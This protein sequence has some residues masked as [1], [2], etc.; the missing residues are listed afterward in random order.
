M[1]SIVVVR[2]LLIALT[3]SVACVTNVMAELPSE[4]G[5]YPQWRGPNRDGISSDKGLLKQWPSGGPKVEEVNGGAP[6][7]PTR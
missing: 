6:S 2:Q 5:D 3:L 4:A 7:I 1:N